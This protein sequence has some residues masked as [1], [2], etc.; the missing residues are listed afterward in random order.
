M[1]RAAS[2]TRRL[3]ICAGLLLTL[4]GINISL[5][6]LG[7]RYS[8]LG[9]LLGHEVL[10]WALLVIV[11]L[12]V[13]LVEGLPLASMELKRPTP[14]TLWAIPAG[15][16]LVVGVPF[17]YFQIFPLLHLHMNSAAISKFAATPFWYRLILVTRAAVCEE[18]L[19]RGYAIPRLEEL[20]GKSS[21]AAA[22][23]WAAFTVAHLNSW[24]WAQLLVAGYGGA[25]L[26]ALFVWRR[27]LAC[28]MLAH[29]IGDGVGFLLG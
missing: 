16:A 6:S 19:C 1:R 5:G 26:T 23:S 14:A 4:G 2:G 22:L 3:Q 15:L 8:R 29:F 12:F 24:G 7:E 18:T 17:I 28:N 9:P 21:L 13:L 27:D 11:V 20:T 10:W 25:I